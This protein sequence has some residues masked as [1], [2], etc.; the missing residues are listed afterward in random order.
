MEGSNEVKQTN[1]IGMIIPF[2]DQINDINGKTITV[3]AL[4][5]Q[6]ALA[7]YLKTRGAFYH[8]TVKGNQKTM[9][10]DIQTCFKER[11]E[12]D[13]VEKPRLSHGRI[14]QRKIWVSSELN[15]YLDFPDVAQVFVIER[16]VTHK[17]SGK[18][19]IETAYGVTS[20][21]ARLASPAKVLRT[22]RE[23]WCIENKCHYIIDWNFN[24]DRSRIRTANGPENMTRLRRFAV[25]L[26]KHKG[27]TNI[28]QKMRDLLMNAR[29]VLDYLRMT[30][31]SCAR[32]MLT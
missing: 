12:P 16:H 9:L 14:E 26:L 17:R 13:F 7:S 22:N 6:R 30:R 31:N 3:D 1:E 18:E 11:K 4:L 28:A 8:F 29:A 24:E 32:P 21:P 25:G 2:L 19:T 10:E 15:D 23:H 5:T 27:V 20:V